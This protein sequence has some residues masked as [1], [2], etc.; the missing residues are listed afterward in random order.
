MYA[1]LMGTFDIPAPIYYLGSV[2]VGKSIVTVIN[3]TN[4]WVLPSHN[5]AQVPLSVVKLVYQVVVNATVDS[6]VTPSTIS[7][8]S[9]EAYLPAWVENSLYSYNFLDMVLS[10]DEP[11]LEAMSG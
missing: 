2:S 11:F 5:E 4:P 1:S 3:R 8:E 10:S 6:I 9:Y 7:K